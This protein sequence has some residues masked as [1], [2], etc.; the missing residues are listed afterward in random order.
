VM[1][2]ANETWISSTL[3]GESMSIGAALAVLQIYESEDEDVCNSLGRVGA[4]M[5][6]SVQSAV[7]A[8]G[9]DGVTVAGL[10][11][12]WFLRFDDPRV[13]RQ[14]LEVAVSEGVLFKRGAYN[15]AALAHDEEETV[16][17]IERAASS[18]FVAVVDGESE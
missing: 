16:V 11:Q 13:E 7:N 2:A 9:I 18:A 4:S 3:A 6:E 8:S 1:E 14:F 5:R 17:E 15:Y 10:D 12:M